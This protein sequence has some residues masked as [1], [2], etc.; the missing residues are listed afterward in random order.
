[1]GLLTQGPALA[2]STK[3]MTHAD[4]PSEGF[5]HRHWRLGGAFKRAAAR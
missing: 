3:Y 1:M 4:P 5:V 2:E